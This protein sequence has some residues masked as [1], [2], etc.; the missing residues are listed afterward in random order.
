[1]GRKKKLLGL[2]AVLLALGT[3]PGLIRAQGPETVVMESISALYG[4]VTFDHAM[5]VD[6][7]G[8]CARCHH[9][10]LGEAPVKE[11]CGRCH[12]AGETAS[13][14]ACR[15][16]HSSERFSSAYLEKIAGDRYLYHTGRP[17]LTG[18][19]HQQCLGCHQEMGAATGCTDCHQRTNKGDAFYRSG[20]YAPK[21]KPAKGH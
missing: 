5:H 10:T 17:G 4:P 13:A 9:H 11:S 12:Q 6:L 1:M 3:L 2:A 8:S 14:I 7:A 18:A 15:D 21:P 20:A 16:C 19:L